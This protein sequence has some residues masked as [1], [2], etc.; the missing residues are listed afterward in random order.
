MYLIVRIDPLSYGV[1]A[2]RALLI[3]GGHFGL[4]ID[5]AVL[6]A[7]AAALLWLGARLFRTI[8]V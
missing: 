8:E 6:V 5:L 2:L 4:G 1:D 7:V 3:N